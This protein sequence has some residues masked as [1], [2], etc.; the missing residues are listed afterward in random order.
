MSPKEN[1]IRVI[2]HNRPDHVPYYTEGERIQVTHGLINRPE[3]AGLDDWGVAWGLAD[4]RL[5]TYPQTP[6]IKSLDDI[7]HYKPP[8][9]ETKGLFDEAEQQI[10]DTD[11]EN[12]LVVAW[13]AAN[14][15]E[16]AWS[17]LGLL[18]VGG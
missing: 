12:T 2:T 6:A 17:L 11:R 14:V 15:F 4:P 18:M 8:D 3:R 7:K 13:N 10:A 5:G 1:I 16:R 9:P